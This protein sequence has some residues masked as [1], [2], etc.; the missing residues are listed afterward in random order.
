[1]R[2]IASIFPAFA[3]FPPY[4]SITITVEHCL[5]Q[6]FLAKCDI[7]PKAIGDLA[8]STHVPIEMMRD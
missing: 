6:K 7:T 2:K 3:T 8:S 4:L 1:V 5:R